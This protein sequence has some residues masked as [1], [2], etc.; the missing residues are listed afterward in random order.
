MDYLENQEEQPT[1]RINFIEEGMKLGLFNGGFGLL[2]MYGG[3]FM[4]I[5]T[6]VTMQFVT[7]FI[8][9]MIAALIIYGLSL[10]KRNNQLLSYKEGLQYSFISYV[11]A[12]VILAIGTYVLYNMIDPELT[13]KTFNIGLE[14]TKSFMERMGAS[15]DEIDKALEKASQGKKETNLSNILLGTGLGLLWDFV[16][17][18]IISL[19]IRK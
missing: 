13:D 3:Y 11:I 8:P 16:K 12:A 19:I 14:K 5:N 1:S 9:Y 7:A 2:L 10:R 6:F 4:G 17:S 18:L 15:Q